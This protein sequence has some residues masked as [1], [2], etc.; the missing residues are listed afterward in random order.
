MWQKC[1]ICN[2]SGQVETDG[3]ST[4]PY[5]LCPTCKGWRIISTI[6]GRPPQINSFEFGITIQAP[7]VAIHKEYPDV[8]PEEAHRIITDWSAE[9]KETY[10]KTRGNIINPFSIEEKF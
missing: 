2:G 6:T 4:N 1:P 3:M 7:N 9:M 5:T 8:T 10:D